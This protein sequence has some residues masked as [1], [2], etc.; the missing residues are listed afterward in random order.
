MGIVLWNF[1][2]EVTT[3]SIASIVSR[4]DLIRKL[5]FPKYV[6]V[7][8]GSFSALIN[9]FLNSIVIAAFMIFS[10]IELRSA[11]LLLPIFILE[12]F[13]FA[14]A[15]GFFLSAAFV[16]YRDVNYI[17]EVVMQGAFYAT[18]IIYPLSLIPFDA[19][20]LLMLNPVAQIM[21]DIRYIMVT[22][23]TMTINDFYGTHLIR[24]FPISVA[25]ILV[26]VSALYF[27]SRSKHFAE[28]V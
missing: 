16:R 9:L 21:Q 8:A 2:A 6:L 25:V 28:E 4:G 19:A 27:R 18:P 14:L 1:F 26:I 24:L 7:L 22:P 10:G 15:I 12:L 5:N 11:A 20:K 17:W 23:E 3:G 13:V